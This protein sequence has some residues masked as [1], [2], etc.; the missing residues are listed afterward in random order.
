[1]DLRKK[2][3]ML[4]G[5]ETFMLRIEARYRDAYDAL[6]NGDYVKAQQILAQLAQSHARTSLSL[7][8]IL[9]KEGLL[10]EDQ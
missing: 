5:F 4:R 10:R 8:S 7:R 6:E 9:I 2:A 1:M 3:A